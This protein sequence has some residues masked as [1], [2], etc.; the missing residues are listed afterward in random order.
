MINRR[1]LLLGALAFSATDAHAV[2]SNEYV[3]YSFIDYFSL[4]SKGLSHSASL[5][6]AAAMRIASSM[7]ADAPLTV[8]QRL[9]QITETG[10]TG[11]VFNSRWKEVANPLIVLFFHD[12]GYQEKQW[13]GDCTPWCAAT[14]AWCLK[15]TGM[16]IPNNP[17]SSHSYLQYGNRVTDPRPGDLC[18][19]TGVDDASIGH[20][21]LYVSR[22]GD[23]L[24]ILGGNQAGQSTTNC[25]T[26]YRQS[27]IC[28]T[29]FPINGDRSR[30]VGL[31][32]LSA[33][34]RPV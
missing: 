28:L 16:P 12:I 24:L 5:D 34:V 30:S 6:I 13:P 3:E 22:F 20:I 1:S 4:K 23:N 27:R 10:S 15:R 7:P 19:F 33:F 32:Y 18:V 31:H 26:G 14:V 21:G 9:S 25:G 11:E 2:D 17:A 8:M 29:E